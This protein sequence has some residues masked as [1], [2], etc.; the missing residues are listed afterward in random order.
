[1][2]LS[3]REFLQSTGLLLAASAVP[4]DLNSPE[5]WRAINPDGWPILQGPTDAT[6]A[7]LIILHPRRERVQ[8]EIKD[9]LGQNVSW[10]I[11]ETWDLPGQDLS[12]SEILVTGLTPLVDYQL[13]LIN[14]AGKIFDRRTFRSLDVSSKSLRFAVAS[15]SKTQ[16]GK[17]SVTMWEA[18]AREKCDLVFLI[19]D[20][21][22]AND[23][24]ESQEGFAWKYAEARNQYSWYRLPR[25]VPTISVW[26]DHDYGS[27]NGDKTWKFKSFMA[28]MFRK[29]YG[30][31]PNT[32]WQPA[33]GMGSVFRAGGQRFYFMDDRSFRDDPRNPNGYEWGS[34]QREWLLADL[35]ASNEPAWIINGTQFFGAYLKTESYE[36]QHTKDFRDFIAKLKTVPAPVSFISGD[37]H[38]SEIMEIEPQALGY[39]TYEFT[40]SSIYSSNFPYFDHRYENPRRIDSEWRHNF[41]VLD[42]DVSAGWKIRARCVKE[43]N[44]IAFDYAYEIRR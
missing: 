34:E 4:T 22:Y 24:E 16:Y 1:M 43:K 31:Q 28:Q 44:D 11:L 23:G 29:F 25:L 33:F 10:T 15:C 37:V 20:T 40:S 41:L 36:G 42:S 8:M 27:N 17:L 5:T 19:G 21:C 6:S 32:I 7:S 3:R 9:P 12:S 39:R 26:D 14:S 18:V 30:A 13:G 35:A 38:F 2:V